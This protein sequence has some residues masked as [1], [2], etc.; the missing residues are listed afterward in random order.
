MENDQKNTFQTVLVFRKPTAKFFV[1]EDVNFNS[2]FGSLYIW[3]EAFVS[4]TE[5]QP[6]F[7]KVTVSIPTAKEIKYYSD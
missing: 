6:E 3:Q 2:Y 1:Y 7:I 5:N 4:F